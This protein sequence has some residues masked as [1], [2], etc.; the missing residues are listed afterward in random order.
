M[1]GV[2]EYDFSGN[3]FHGVKLFS[4]EAVIFYSGFHLPKLLGSESDSHGFSSYFASPLVT[5]TAPDAMRA[6]LHR[7]LAEITH[8]TQLTAQTIVGLFPA[9]CGVCLFHFQGF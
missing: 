8:L 3:L 1:R 9:S 5:R 6:V 7:T 2:E 4:E